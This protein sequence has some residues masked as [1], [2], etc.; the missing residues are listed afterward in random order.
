MMC[1]V[2]NWELVQSFGTSQLTWL[3]THGNF[4]NGMIPPTIWTE[5]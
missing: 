3:K 2:D 1:G 4:T 5:S